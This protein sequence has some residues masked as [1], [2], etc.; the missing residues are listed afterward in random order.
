MNCANAIGGGIA[1][2]STDNSCNVAMGPDPLLGPLQDNGGPTPTR[3]PG[4]GSPV[5]DAAPCDPS[6]TVDQRG[7]P[8]PQDGIIDGP[9][10][11]DIG[12]VEV[13]P[14]EPTPPPSSPPPTGP[15]PA[16][17]SFTG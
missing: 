6:V 8:R 15:V 9:V 14:R 4:R 7:A 16:A 2:Y 10:T 11:C 17:P 13:A 3:Y 12:S 1:S 5:I